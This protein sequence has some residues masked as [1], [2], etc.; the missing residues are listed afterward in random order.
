MLFAVPSGFDDPYK[1]I[2]EIR[3]PE[4]ILEQHFVEY[5]NKGRK[6]KKLE[7]EKT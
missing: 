4:I 7:S 2:R 5:K 3:K 1:K 6:D